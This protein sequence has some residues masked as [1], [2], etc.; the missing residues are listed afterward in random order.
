MIDLENL[1]YRLTRHFFTGLG[2]DEAKM[3]RL[4]YGLSLM[5]GLSLGAILCLLLS[6]FIGT[7]FFTALIMSSSFSL[8]FF[9]GGTHSSTFS[10]CL[11]ITVAVF[12]PASILA[13]SLCLQM[14]TTHLHLFSGIIMLFMV[15]YLLTTVKYKTLYILAINGAVLIAVYFSGNLTKALL[16]VTLGCLIQILMTA[17]PGAFLIQAVDKIV[18]KLKTQ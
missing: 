12:I 7:L 6:L 5:L 13:R 11:F 4:E 14:S 1:S 15:I 10:T 8:R 2:L 9:T 3:A 16:S 17:R 18:L